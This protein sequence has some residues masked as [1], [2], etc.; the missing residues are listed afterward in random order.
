ME[1]VGNLLD[2]AVPNLERKKSLATEGSFDVMTVNPDE[3]EL[4]QEEREEVLRTALEAKRAKIRR[5]QYAEKLRQE[6]KPKKYTADDYWQ[7]FHA[8]VKAMMGEGQEWV[9][10]K[11]N[12]NIINAL[13]MYFAKDVGFEKIKEGFSLRKGIMLY[14]PYGCGKTAIMQA[15]TVNQNMSYRCVSVLKLDELYQIH[16]APIILEYSGHSE[17][18]VEATSMFHQK[19]GG[20]CFDDLGQERAES[21]HYANKTDVVGQILRHRYYS[22]LGHNYTH[23]TT[24]ATGQELAEIYPFLGQSGRLKEMFNFIKFHEDAPNRR[25]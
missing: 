7:I 21:A 1:K 19:L 17:I 2:A 6:P 4:T 23:A 11:W 20:Y 9:T 15:F 3:V 13:C 10:D 14:G 18:S 25:K 8:K 5:I 12:K 16:G 24:N 22:G